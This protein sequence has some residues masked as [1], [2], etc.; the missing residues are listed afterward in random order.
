MVHPLLR[1]FISILRWL[2]RYWR[3]ANLVPIFNLLLVLK[4]LSWILNYLS[5][6]LPAFLCCS[7]FY[8][9]C[10][11]DLRLWWWLLV[12]THNTVTFLVYKDN[13]K[14]TTQGEWKTHE[15]TLHLFSTLFGSL[16]ACLAM[17][18]WF[19]KIRETQSVVATG[20]SMIANYIWYQHLIWGFMLYC[21]NS[22]IQIPMFLRFDVYSVLYLYFFE[23]Q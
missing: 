7:A 18:I 13:Q 17:V 14:R 5:L 2:Q 4:Q 22:K 11:N 21:F 10:T 6:F 3:K 20:V 1:V 8:S 15:L 16:G 19:H 23:I 9:K 12:S